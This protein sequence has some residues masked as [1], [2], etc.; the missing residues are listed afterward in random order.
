MITISLCMIVK[1]EEKNLDR[2]LSCLAPYMDEI[3]I[4]DTCSRDRTKE[5]AARYTD[6]IFDYTW[7][8]DF[9]K[10]RNFVFA[11]ASMQYIYSADADEVLDGTNQERLRILKEVLLPEIDIVQMYYVN[12]LMH[13][14][15][16]NFD[17]EYRPKLFK[18]IRTFE[19]TDPIHET[20]RTQ[21]VIF[22]SDIEIL[23]CPGESHAGRDLDALFSLWEKGE[24]LSRRLREMY[25][26]ELMIAGT[27]ADFAKAAPAFRSF[28]VDPCADLDQTR[29]ACCILAFEAFYRKDIHTFFTNALK[30]IA[31][32]GCSEICCL[33]GDYYSEQ[34]EWDDAALW[35][36][37]AA[38]ETVPILNLQYKESYPA[39][40]LEALKAHLRE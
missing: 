16:Y 37:N 40:C 10:A 6:L 26:R 9:S 13:N 8:D 21:P 5:I 3:I 2:C 14:T 12:Q 4:A 7:E 18:R 24:P 15:V 17:K 36:E 29:E 27:P 33:L 35:Y 28:L 32:D 38:H 11:K 23:H 31:S 30:L 22:D 25:A 20:I 1:N 34:K 19:W 39:K